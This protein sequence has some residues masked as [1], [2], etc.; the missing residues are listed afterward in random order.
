MLG[1]AQILD[2]TTLND[3]QKSYIK[4]INQSGEALL[5]IINDIL[6]F[7]KIESGEL[8]LESNNF[9]L[10]TLAQ[11]ATQLFS[12]QAKEKQIY[13]NLVYDEITP[14]HFKGDMGRLRQVLLNLLGNAI[15][16]TEQGKVTLSVCTTQ[17]S[18]DNYTLRFV[19]DDTGIGIAEK[20]R[21][22]LFGAFQQADA[23]TTRKFGGTGLGLAI[24]KKLIQLMGGE[25]GFD[26]QPG[27]G[28]QFWFEITLPTA[29]ANRENEQAL[30]SSA[31][32]LPVTLNGSVLLVED[33][34]INQ[35]VAQEMLE[36]TGLIVEI[37]TD[38]KQALKLWKERPYDLILMD[39]LMPEMDGFEATRQIRSLE[40]DARI[41]IIALTANAM[42]SDRQA[43]NAAGMDD[44]ISK[45]IKIDL[46][47]NVLKKWLNA[48]S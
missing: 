45:P 41:P 26:S 12:P 47:H 8:Q 30:D 16:F 2:R 4:T 27:D 38:G 29:Q 14:S 48:N 31:I 19:I 46:L 32:H 10:L 3:L 35:L 13:L 33:N 11:E 28:S 17:Q 5:I 37:A 36:S 18:H 34:P 43:C 39:C 24:C 9:N 42:E 23:T 6:D 15:K 40:K 25:I 21:H 44:F 20:D 22:K 1:M 7:S